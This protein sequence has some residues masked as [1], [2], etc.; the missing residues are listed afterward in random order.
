LTDRD[1]GSNAEAAREMAE[2][3]DWITPTLNGEPRFAKPVFIYWLMSGA[4][5]MFGVNEFTARLPSALF[6]V[7]L[8]ALQYWFLARTKNSIIAMFGGL[9]LLL[10]V[11]MVTIGRL[12]LT[13]SVL[14]FFTTL[15]LY[16]FWLG[17]HGQGLQHHYMWLFYV[18]M[19]FGTLT[20]GP[21]GFVVPLLGTIPYL[22]VAR[23]WGRFWSQGFPLTGLL[24]FLVLT[25]PWYVTML[26]LHSSRY[27]ASAQADTIGRFFNV[28]GGHGGTILFYF[29]VVL[30]GFFPW[31]G[32]LP[33]ALYD[34]VKRWG[35]IGG[36]RRIGTLHS[37]NFTSEHEFE[38][39]VAL[40]AVAGFVFF[41]A[42]ATRLPHYIGPL[43]PA[44]ASLVAVYWHRC[45]IDPRTRGTR[46]AIYTTMSI[47]YA[48][49]MALV[50]AS[51]LYTLFLE[52][53]AKEFP[54]APQVVPGIAPVIAG[55]IVLVGMGMVG[56]FGLSEDRR[57]GTFWAAGATIALVLLIAT[58]TAIPR[59]SYYF[60]E[61][62][63][64]LAYIAGINLQPQD[65]LIFY[66]PPRP[67]WLFYAKRRAIMIRPGQEEA[68]QASLTGSDRT[69]ILLPS[70][71]KPHLPQEAAGYTVLLERYGYTLLANKPMVQV[72][73]STAPQPSVPH[74]LSR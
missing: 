22:T 19:A 47:G 12:A 69:M 14:I 18:G 31:S 1:E 13:D 8:I 28:I 59:F 6:G 68:L 49:G 15:S 63:Q 27:T 66:G 74:G 41:S 65:R 9:I 36:L 25:A 39:F 35:G 16:G 60:I 5:K 51:P 34:A 17:L 38:L 45:L 53:I 62:P 73:P 43:Y 3:G 37:P 10:N 20:K 42:S 23:R 4:Y 67:S 44:M 64:N 55:F 7:G 58:G 32:L 11:E 48:L 56:Y 52:K 29:P 61:P 33:F 71:L 26:V 40:W 30:L 54:M 21:I 2:T 72:S 46:G 70:R 57:A 50:A 24:L